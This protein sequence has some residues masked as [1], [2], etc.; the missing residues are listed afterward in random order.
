MSD[1]RALCDDLAAE[2]AALDAL[3]AALPEV[4]WDT[5]TPAAGWTVRDQVG[6]L[7]YYDGQARLAVEDPNRFGVEAS[8]ATQEQL[9]QQHLAQGRR[10][11][12]DALLAWWRAARA[13][14]LRALRG[15]HQGS[16]VPWYGPPM[17]AATFISARLMETWSHGHDVADALGLALPATARL[18]HVAHLGVRTR[19]FSYALR[20]LTPPAAEVRVELNG[21]G[22]ERWCWGDERAPDRVVGPARDFCLVVTQRRHPADTALA[23]TGPLASEW[24]SLAQA[25]AGRPGAGRPPGLFPQRP[26]PYRPATTGGPTEG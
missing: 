3:V 24:L 14:L 20:G 7:A 9:E 18:R 12:G 11:T 4:A 26:G 19:A 23:A 15:L 10:L 8:G 17:G 13:A 5:P 2:H 6:H 21:P 22:G 1:L 16:R 25:F